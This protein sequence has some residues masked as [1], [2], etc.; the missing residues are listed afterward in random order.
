MMLWGLHPDTGEHKGIYIE[1]TKL[2]RP[3]FT[4]GTLRPRKRL[5]LG[6]GGEMGSG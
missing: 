1:N 6:L 2:V 5:G 4:S 3:V